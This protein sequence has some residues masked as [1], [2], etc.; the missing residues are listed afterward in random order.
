M[1][2]K[3]KGS[4]APA[5]IAGSAMEQ[6]GR[7]TSG[8]RETMLP[9]SHRAA[10]AATPPPEIWRRLTMRR[11]FSGKL[12]KNPLLPQPVHPAAVWWGIEENQ[13]LC[14]QTTERLFL[15][16]LFKNRPPHFHS[17]FFFLYKKGKNLFIC[18]SCFIHYIYSALIFASFG[19]SDAQW[20]QTL[21]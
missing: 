5:S 17:R 19:S 4:I 15:L 21:S 3:R 20:W 10:A 16:R 9:R 11:R 2:S 14:N 12:D 1:Q 6:H 13:L 7:S 18:S 8:T